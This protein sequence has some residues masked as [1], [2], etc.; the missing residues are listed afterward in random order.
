MVDNHP[1]LIQ[2]RHQDAVLGDTSNTV[3]KGSGPQNVIF[4]N[5]PKIIF[6]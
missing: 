1:K 2:R 5:G 4:S 6:E 3:D